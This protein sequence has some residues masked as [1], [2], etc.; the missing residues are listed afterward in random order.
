MRIYRK[1]IHLMFLCRKACAELLQLVDPSSLSAGTT[2][3]A[4]S[5]SKAMA[6]HSEALE[7]MIF[8]ETPGIIDVAKAR[9]ALQQAAHRHHH[10]HRHNH[11]QRQQRQR[12]HHH[13]RLNRQLHILRNS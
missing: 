3:D 5:H 13:M 6:R 12:H 4:V 8:T 9:I 10:H 2:R 1:V 11:R 7:E